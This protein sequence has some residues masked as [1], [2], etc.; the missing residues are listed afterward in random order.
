[1]LPIT[2]K[3]PHVIVASLDVVELDDET[4]HHLTRVRRLRLGDPITVS[5]GRGRWAEGRWAGQTV[6]LTGPPV[7]VA[8]PTVTVSVAF[9]L[10]KGG[11]PELVVQKLTELG[12]DRIVPFVS[13]RSVVRWDEVRGTR[14]HARLTRVAR[15]AAQQSKRIWLPEVEPVTSF[16]DLAG[17]AGA[18]VAD[19]VGGPL[20]GVPELVLVGPE[21]G[22]SEVERE[23]GLS[24]VNLGDTVLRAETAAIVVGA[25]VCA[26]RGGRVAAVGD[27]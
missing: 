10:V 23:A 2:S 13:E 5:D 15:E 18:V 24:S 9:S 27:G 21:G 7:E 25:L 6:E 8:R 19:L 16:A 12:V 3:G 26:L 11:R 4:V 22:W 1:M 20:T 17:R 14:H